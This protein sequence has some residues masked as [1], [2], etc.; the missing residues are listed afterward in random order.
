[1]DDDTDETDAEILAM[2]EGAPAC[3]ADVLSLAE[4]AVTE[5]A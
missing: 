5:I 2:L 4:Q 3:P 1:M